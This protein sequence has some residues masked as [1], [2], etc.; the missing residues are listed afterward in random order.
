M[1]HMGRIGILNK[2]QPFRDIHSRVLERRKSV[3]VGRNTRVGFKNHSHLMVI[4]KQAI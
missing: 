1:G 2:F 3:S 4:K